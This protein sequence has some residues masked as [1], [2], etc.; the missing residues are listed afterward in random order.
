MLAVRQ[1]NHFT[2][3]LETSEFMQVSPFSSKVMKG[4]FSWEAFLNIWKRLVFAED[5]FAGAWSKDSAMLS[6]WTWNVF[7]NGTP[8]PT[9]YSACSFTD[10][11][12]SSVNIRETPFCFVP[13]AHVQSTSES[14]FAHFCLSHTHT[15][16]KSGFGK[17][18]HKGFGYS[19]K[20]GKAVFVCCFFMNERIR[21]F[22]EA[23]C[24]SGTPC[25]FWWF[26]GT[27]TV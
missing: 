22:W 15:T 8:I 18:Q 27:N 10:A 7:I 17:F 6:A 14:K 25:W 23:I 3:A 20:I 11:M 26:S 4:H 12:F 1:S 13:F 21:N 16:S 24:I 9:T 19:R 2:T 5:G